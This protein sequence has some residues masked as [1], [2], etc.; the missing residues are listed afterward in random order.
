MKVGQIMTREVRVCTQSDSLNRAAQL[1][2]DNDC[3][4]V[5]VISANGDGSLIGMLTDRDICMAAYTEGKPLLEIPV[6]TAM[7]KTV[8][9]CRPG[10]DI[11]RVE[12]L[13]KKN[14]IRRIAVVDERGALQGIVSINDL[15]CEAEH[16]SA[17]KA[18]IEITEAEIGETLAA[19]CRHRSGKIFD[20]RT[21]SV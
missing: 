11:R 16:E 13:M 10:D 5:P 17:A 18:G 8:I 6:A 2:W 3:G 20:R 12:A 14:Q 4:C 21:P 7:A 15:A 9:S 1:M 19:V